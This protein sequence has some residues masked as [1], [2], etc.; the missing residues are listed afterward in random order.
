MKNYKER[1]K[2]EAIFGY[3]SEE[4]AF[5]ERCLDNIEPYEKDII[6]K[7]LI[8]NV[9]VRRYAQE[10]G[11]SRETITNRRNRIIKML[12]KFFNIYSGF[13]PISSGNT[14]NKSIL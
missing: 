11:Y 1:K 9:S 13:A 10:S 2:E 6:E 5:I 8:E 3:K 4:T 14:Q 7:T 12:T